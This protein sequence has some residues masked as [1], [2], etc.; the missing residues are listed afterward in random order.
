MVVEKNPKNQEK[1]DENIRPI[2]GRK[3]ETKRLLNLI[4]N[5]LKKGERNVYQLTRIASKDGQFNINLYNRIRF[6][7]MELLAMG[8]V[9][10]R[11]GEGKKTKVWFYSLVEDKVK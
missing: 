3:S 8:E 5:E 2:L 4:K 1:N 9:K 6:L 10:R 11:L 7:L